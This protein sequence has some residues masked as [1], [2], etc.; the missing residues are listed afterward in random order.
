MSD[1]ILT[2]AGVVINEGDEQRSQTQKNLAD[3]QYCPDAGLPH[4]GVIQDLQRK[5]KQDQ[6]KIRQVGQGAGSPSNNEPE[7]MPPA[8]IRFQD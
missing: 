6:Q 7:P 8:G 2:P 3:W 5:A 1:E 4:T